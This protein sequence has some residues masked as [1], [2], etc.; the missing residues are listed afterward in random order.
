MTV[1]AFAILYSFF[2]DIAGAKAGTPAEHP[3]AKAE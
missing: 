2:E 1:L 3:I